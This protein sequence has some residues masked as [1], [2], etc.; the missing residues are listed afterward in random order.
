MANICSNY[1][2]FSGE[3]ENVNNFKEYL[4]VIVEL[5]DAVI[6]LENY[7]AMLS[8]DLSH[9]D[10]NQID[11]ESRWSSPIDTMKHLAQGYHLDMECEYSELGCGLFGKWIYYHKTNEEIDIQL[12]DNDMNSVKE[13]FINDGFDCMYRFDGEDYEMIEEPYDILLNRMYKAYLETLMKPVDR[14][15]YVY[16]R[17]LVYDGE[18][19]Y[20]QH[21]LHIERG[22]FTA[23]DAMKIAGGYFG[24]G[25]LIDGCFHFFS[26]QV[27]VEVIKW[28][29]L[30]LEEFKIINPVLNN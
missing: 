7:K 10:N 4:K 29:E 19:Q 15:K 13:V 20:L 9:I 8:I 12:D 18:R 2:S 28:R 3:E 16:I 21:L 30:T 27:I 23:A 1:L 6:Q 14:K 24:K 11:F 25:E 17:L 22:V 26:S 5:H